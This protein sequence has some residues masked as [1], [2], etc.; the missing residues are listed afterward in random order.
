M[1]FEPKTEKQ[2]AEENLGVWSVRGKID[3]LGVAGSTLFAF[4]QNE[5]FR[6]LANAAEPLKHAF[7]D[8][9]S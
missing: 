3:G 7:K 6:S 5:T 8:T 4:W 1:N 2:L 9:N